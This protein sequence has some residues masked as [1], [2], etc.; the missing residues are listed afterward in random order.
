MWWDIIKALDKAVIP[1][2]LKEPLNRA[3]RILE[4][5]R[6]IETEVE[7]YTGYPFSY[8]NEDMSLQIE[9]W[10]YKK[11]LQYR[12]QEM[13]RKFIHFIEKNPVFY[14]KGVLHG[15][16]RQETFEGVMIL[17]DGRFKVIPKP[18]TYE[19]SGI[20]DNLEEDYTSG[21]VS[22]YINFVFADWDSYITITDS[23]FTT[24]E[25]KLEALKN[26]GI[27]PGPLDSLTPEDRAI[28]RGIVEG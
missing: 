10:V 7:D 26:T 14:S 13:I 12:P 2:H 4:G 16:K 9:I 15:S 23:V 27:K 8:S 6:P 1:S 25:K 17:G 22:F 28:V 21:V 18:L 19:A 5:R 24:R 20:F 3:L 11:Y